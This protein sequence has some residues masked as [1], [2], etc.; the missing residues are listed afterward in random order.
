M[1]LNSLR[2]FLAVAERGSLRAAARQL[3]V[4]QPAITRNIQELEKELGVVLFE[5]QARGVTLS[6]MG[7]VFLRRA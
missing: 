6:P 1:K 4:A 5:R 2:D 7:E 3:G